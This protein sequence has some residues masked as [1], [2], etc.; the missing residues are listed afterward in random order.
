MKDFFVV[1]GVMMR[2]WLRPFRPEYETEADLDGAR[3]S[4]LAGYDCREMAK[5]FLELLDRHRNGKLPIPEFFRSHPAELDRHQAIMDEYRKLQ[6]E[7]PND[8]LYIGTDN[9]RK[10][11]AWKR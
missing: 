2:T 8:N 11:I 6:A 1:G 10:R 9:L 5:L 3:W 4:F 7:K